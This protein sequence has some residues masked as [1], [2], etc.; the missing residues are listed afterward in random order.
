M[1]FIIAKFSLLVRLT[2]KKQ[3]KA[4]QD[5]IDWLSILHPLF[6]KFA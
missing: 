1:K 5:S 2:G 4:N 3:I 6:K